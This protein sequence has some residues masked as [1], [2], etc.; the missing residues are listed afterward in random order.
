MVLGAL[1]IIV[2]AFKPRGLIP[3]KKLF[4]PGINYEGIIREEIQEST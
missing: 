3:E 4:I 2:M 1:L